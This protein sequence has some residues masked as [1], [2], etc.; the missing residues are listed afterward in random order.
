[1]RGALDEDAPAGPTR[2]ADHRDHFT[3][4]IEAALEAA[5]PV[6]LVRSSL[7]V[8]AGAIVSG[9]HRLA[10][11][12]SSRVYLIALGKAAPAMTQAAAE[13]LQDR[14]E[15]GVAAIPAGVPAEFPAG[16]QTF[17]G[18]HPLPTQGSLEAGRACAELLARV[19]AEDRVVVLVSGGG[20][21]MFELPVEGVALDNLRDL[22]KRLLASGAPIDEMNAVRKALSQVKGGG[23]AQMASPAPVLGLVLSDVV[24]DRLSAVASGPTLLQPQPS[25]TPRAVLERYNLWEQV[26]PSVRQAITRNEPG[27]PPMYQPVN[28]LLGGNRLALNA[29]RRVAE[30]LGFQASVLTTTLE[31]EA[32]QLGHEFGEVLKSAPVNSCLLQGGEPTVTVRGEGRGGRNQ[33]FAVAA[34]LALEGAPSRAVLSFA[35]DGRDGPTDAAGAVVTGETAANIRAAGLELEEH[36]K[37]NNAY[38]ALD[39]ADA[40]IKT[41]PTGTNVNDLVVGLVYAEP[42]DDG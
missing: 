41:G 26:S 21:A 42:S 15:A 6:A 30:D 33:E 32:S 11:H 18:G 25:A 17:E 3:R 40:L 13:M 27:S 19:Q 9:P 29:A 39:A 10:L 24:G 31:G 23:L 4:M 7:E 35:T 16:V 38:P 14:L 12:E 34:A 2:F 20:S 36:L 28:V 37:E 22:N 5:D 8:K 1:M